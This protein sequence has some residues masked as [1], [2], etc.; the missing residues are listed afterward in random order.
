MFYFT[1]NSIEYLYTDYK[2]QKFHKSSYTCLNLK[3]PA[4][5]EGDVRQRSWLRH[6]ATS[7]KVPSSIPDEAIGFFNYLKPSS[8]IMALGLTQ[9]LTE[10]STRNPPGSNG[11][12][13]RKADNL[14][15][16]SEQIV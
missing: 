15:A 10:L 2:K 3:L 5:S 13:V 12:P 8:R 1:V 7:R 6:Y 11:R 4:L 16:I 9:P 14:T